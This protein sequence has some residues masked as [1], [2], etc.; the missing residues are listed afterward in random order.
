MYVF[1]LRKHTLCSLGLKII[2]YTKLLQYNSWSTYT[3]AEYNQ[4]LAQVYTPAEYNQYIAPVYIP[5]EYG[6][7]LIS[8]YTPVEYGQYLAQVYSTPLLSMVSI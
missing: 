8:V 7:Y 6:Q 5:A 2:W 3:P 4:Y 1:L